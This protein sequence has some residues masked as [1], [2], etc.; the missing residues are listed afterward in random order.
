M[1]PI[2]TEL[3]LEATKKHKLLVTL[4]ENVASGGFGEKVRECLE[5]NGKDN[6]LLTIHI[7]DEYVEH[8]NVDLLREEIGI[9]AKSIYQ[10]IEEVLGR[11]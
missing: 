5:S 4:E 11:L 2:D 10:R 7:P 3:V 1:K 8:G 9:D 6:E